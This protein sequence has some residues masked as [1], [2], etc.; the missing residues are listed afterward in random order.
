MATL[1]KLSRHHSDPRTRPITRGYSALM[2]TSR[3]VVLVHGVPE[4]SAIWRPLATA[5]EDR[6]GGDVIAL[7]PPGFGAPVPDG[8]T[9]SV[10]S[11]V[12]WLAD[13]L[14]GIEGEIDLVGHDWGAGHLYGLLA[15]RPGLVRTWAADIAGI[16][17][18]DYQWHDMAQAWQTPDVGE[19]VIAGMTG[20]TVEERSALFV[21]LGLPDDIAADLGAHLDEQMG[22]CI[23][24]LYREASQ[25]AMSELGDRVVAAE[26]PP[27]LV[28]DPTA[29]EYVS[30][31][32]SNE[33]AARLSADILRL[34]GRGHWWMVRDVDEVADGLVAFWAAN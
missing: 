28:I 30:A 23:L 4:T 14:I 20:G 34:D 17:H 7:S 10:A 29:D 32:L 33:M 21:G 9:P 15:S 13:Q 8:F 12:S 31:V 26:R 25:P 3:T 2:A 11:Y 5:L 1:R 16:I 27:G 22:R 24:P 19:Q 18:R 6:T